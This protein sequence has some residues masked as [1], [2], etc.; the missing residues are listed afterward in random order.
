MATVKSLD[1]VKPETWWRIFNNEV[2]RDGLLYATG[3]Q[4]K[5]TDEAI[6]SSQDGRPDALVSEW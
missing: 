1:A 6:G 3:M 4:T 5:R 2:I